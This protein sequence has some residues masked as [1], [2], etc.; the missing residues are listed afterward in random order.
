MSRKDFN[1]IANALLAAPIDAKSKRVA[2]WTLAHDLKA[3][4]PRF[5]VTRFIDA[6]CGAN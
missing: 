6:A 5:D 1:L 3:T 4:N 2:A